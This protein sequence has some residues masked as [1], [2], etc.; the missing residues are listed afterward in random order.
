VAMNVVEAAREDRP[1]HHLRQFGGCSI[2]GLHRLRYRREWR[3][4]PNL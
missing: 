1:R 4:S 2:A 3:S